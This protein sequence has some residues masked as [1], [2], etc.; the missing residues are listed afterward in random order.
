MMNLRFLR[1]LFLCGTGRVFSTEENR[2]I[3][4]VN[5]FACIGA[6]FSLLYFAFYLIFPDPFLLINQCIC[7]LCWLAGIY[8]NWKQKPK[9]ARALLV[10]NA[11]WNVLLDTLTFGKEG[12]GF[13]GY[14]LILFSL[15]LVYDYTQ[16]L[17][18]FCAFSFTIICLLVIHFYSSAFPIKNNF[19]PHVIETIYYANIGIILFLSMYVAY[20]YLKVT[21][22]Q[23][24]VL[25]KTQ[26]ELHG[27]Q[28][29]ETQSALYRQKERYKIL[30]DSVH[31]AIIVKSPAG[32]IIDINE[33]TL[34]ML[35]YTREEMFRLGVEAILHPDSV[36]D[37][38][39]AMD[40]S[41]LEDGIS[42]EI[43]LVG[44]HGNKIYTNMRTATFKHE[45]ADQTVLS[46]DDITEQKKIAEEKRIVQLNR[47]KELL[48][49]IVKT[50]DEERKRLAE[51]IHDGL[52]HLLT[53]AKMNLS[54]AEISVSEG[55]GVDS[56]EYG[57]NENIKNAMDIINEA[58]NECKTI[59]AGLLSMSLK[60]VGLVQAV[61]N[62]CYKMNKMEGARI[63]FYSN[64]QFFGYNDFI[65]QTIYRI[66]QE[67]IHNAF[68]H[69]RADEINLQLFNRDGNVI[70]HIEDDGIGFNFERDGKGMGLNNIQ[71]RVE[72]LNGNLQIDSNI[73]RG[74]TIIIEIP[75]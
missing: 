16:K 51:N 17:E 36:E 68:K 59:S 58:M 8:I 66:C 35:G 69:A 9:V 55:S 22:A 11:N 70:I 37:Y 24:Q 72:I 23:Q 50:Q 12:G 56:E 44:K 46:F 5:R 27:I 13:L 64:T 28:V 29:K 14:F 63:V 34:S 31:D 49:V 38:H 48:S 19:A 33:A 62:L 45:N 42:Q 71:S 7:F 57:V 43:V 52:G 1:G 18:L 47:Q 10:F 6:I 4:I 32:D 53:A 39:V 30:F 25:L 73:G 67:L 21:D 20:Y 3:V 60:D 54:A 65:H 15:V 61:R 26:E 74:C 2:K 41:S 40:T 75:L